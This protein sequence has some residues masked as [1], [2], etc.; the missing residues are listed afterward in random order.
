MNN[1]EEITTLLT[2]MS[3]G[4]AIAFVVGI[5]RGVIQQKHGGIGALIR[6]AVASV[7]VGVIVTWGLADTGLSV[8]SKGAITAISAFIA[9][10]ILLGLLS[11]GA[12]I[13]KDPLG[14]FARLLAAYRG[15]ASAESKKEGN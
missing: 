8:T 1:K 9:D 11:L 7:L 4:G 2:A 10:D 6:G 3:A 14:F 5:A 13:G 12:L 15:Q